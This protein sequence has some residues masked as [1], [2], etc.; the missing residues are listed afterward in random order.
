MTTPPLPFPYDSSHLEAFRR[1]LSPPRFNHYCEHTSGDEIA[2][3]QLYTWNCSVA[4]AFHGPLQ[5]FEITLRNRV[6]ERMSDVHG[7]G[8]FHRVELLGRRELTR[9]QEVLSRHEGDDTPTHDDVVSKLGLGFWVALFSNHYDTT[10]WRSD[11]FWLFPKGT[12]RPGLFRNLKELGIL[13]NRIAH[14][15]P[16]FRREL[17]SDYEALKAVLRLLCPVTCD[18]VDHG[19]RVWDTLALAPAEVERF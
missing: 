1:A 12:H 4:S 2:A 18:W 7:R 15:E 5:A 13:R 6:D 8:W 16:I 3:M 9:V 17:A 10:L 14:H 11:L 19:S